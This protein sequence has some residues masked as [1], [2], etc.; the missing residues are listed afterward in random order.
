[1]DKDK[2]IK[3]CAA[4]MLGNYTTFTHTSI[5]SAFKTDRPKEK[6]PGISVLRNT[7]TLHL[8][9]SGQV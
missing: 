7:H 8:A 9:A 2:Q 4:Y 5:S 6:P 1:M 3:R